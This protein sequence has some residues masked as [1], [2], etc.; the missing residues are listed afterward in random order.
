[1]M[2]SNEFLHSLCLAL[3]AV[4]LS[5]GCTKDFEGS[6]DDP[7]KEEI[8]DDRWN[9]TDARKTAQHLIS[10]CLKKPWLSSFR[11]K[12]QGERPV[13]LVD[14]VGNSTDEHIDVKALTDFIRDELINSGKIR[15]VNK[16]RRQAILDELKYQGSGAV[17]EKSAKQYGRQTGADFMLGGT[18]TSYVHTQ[19][20]LKTVTYQTN[21][22]LTNLETSEIE[23]SEKYQIKKRFNR[24]SANW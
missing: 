13:V 2:I 22:I 3:A 21:L 8:V 6:Y 23:W 1:M 10:S 4:L 15:F 5:V 24:S 11:R 16:A 7:L 20:G 9:E 17:S 18:I 14:E 19:K 12:E